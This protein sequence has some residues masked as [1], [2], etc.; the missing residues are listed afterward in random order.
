[1]YVIFYRSSRGH[2]IG[3][4]FT[5]WSATRDELVK[6]HKRHVEAT[7]K[8]AEGRVIGQ[9]W[10]MDRRWYWYIETDPAAENGVA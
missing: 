1:M 7:A 3:A 9:V 10:K 4:Y 8:N 2:P 5:T 6:L